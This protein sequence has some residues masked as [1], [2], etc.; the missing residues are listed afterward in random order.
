M[1]RLAIVVTHPIQY[2]APVFGLLTQ[3]GKVKV[4]VFYTWGNQSQTQFDPGFDK[5]VSW[6]IPLLDGYEYTFVKNTSS[7]PGSHHFWGIINPQLK[8]EI[9]DWA[10][11]AL[12][13]YGWSYYSHLQL[14]L[15][16]GKHLPVLFR[17]DSHLLDHQPSWKK[18]MKK[19]LLKFIY[20]YISKVLYVGINNKAYFQYYGIKES[21]LIYA[22]HAVD[23]QRFSEND[24]LYN[25]Q[26]QNWRLNLGINPNDIVVLFAG[27]LEPKKSP[28]LLL[29]AVQ[30]YNETT[31][32]S[33]KLI[34]VGNGVLETE[35]KELAERD[36]NIFFINFQNQ[37]QMP[38]VYRMGDLFCLPS[39][40]PGETWG[41]AV[42]EAMACGRPVIVSDQVGCAVDLVVSGETGY[43][44][45][46]G[47]V[48]DLKNILDKINKEE[49]KEMGAAASKLIKSWSFEKQIEALIGQLKNG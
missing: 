31:T 42:N 24:L 20:S 5:N 35:L 38:I 10:P 26:A 49:L 37:S 33:I 40:G 1:K 27:K 15:K 47:D 4:K 30:E 45:K 28:D 14:I 13:I 39:R 48:V 36:T 2:Y 19:V 29:K 43:I 25:E 11:D 21:Q 17:G 34:F 32:T 9:L 41:L 23:N 44:L 18:G 22:P 7:N 3:R 12:L 16:L 8:K 46:S 6:D